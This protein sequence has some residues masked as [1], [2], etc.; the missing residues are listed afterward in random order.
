MESNQYRR[1]YTSPDAHRMNNGRQSTKTPNRGYEDSLQNGKFDGEARDDTTVNGKEILARRMPSIILRGDEKGRRSDAV[2]RLDNEYATRRG[3]NY[4]VCEES[5]LDGSIDCEDDRFDDAKDGRFDDAKEDFNSPLVACGFQVGRYGAQQ[6]G[7]P[8]NHNQSSDCLLRYP[9][10]KA[11]FMVPSEAVPRDVLDCFFGAKCLDQK[12]VKL[13]ANPRHTFG[14]KIQSIYE[15]HLQSDLYED[16]DLLLAARNTMAHRFNADSF[17]SAKTT[18][19]EFLYL[20][21]KIGAQLDAM[22]TDKEEERRRRRKRN[23]SF[24]GHSTDRAQKQCR[25]SL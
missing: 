12:L 10:E 13:G 5:I 2:A 24:G 1:L 4:E 23:H 21:K 16:L 11:S 15:L 9:D 7:Q 18:R 14:E 8:G 17:D 3:A 22:I 6:Q 19:Q 20:V 25:R